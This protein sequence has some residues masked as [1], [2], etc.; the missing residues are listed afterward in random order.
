M[1]DSNCEQLIQKYC[2]SP[3]DDQKADVLLNN[4]EEVVNQRVQEM[5]KSKNPAKKQS[6]QIL[7]LEEELKKVEEQI[8]Q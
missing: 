4:F 7:V 2:Q 5:E 1:N 3:L 6:K 8:Q